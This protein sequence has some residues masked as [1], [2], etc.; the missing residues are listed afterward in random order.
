[1]AAS[2][3]ASLA[4][5]ASPVPMTGWTMGGREGPDEEAELYPSERWEGGGGSGS[6]MMVA[7][8]AACTYVSFA[9]RI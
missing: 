6:A 7:L 5:A 9:V 3:S 8:R 4:L 2:F 1:M